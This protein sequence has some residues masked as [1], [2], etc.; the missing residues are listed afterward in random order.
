VDISGRVIQ[1]VSHEGAQN[2]QLSLSTEFL[3]P[4]VYIFE[5]IHNSERQVVRLVKK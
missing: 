1:S 3:A 2:Q 5:I 4:G